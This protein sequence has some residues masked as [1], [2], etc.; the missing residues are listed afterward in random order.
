MISVRS[1][2]SHPDSDG[3]HVSPQRALRS[4]GNSN[5]QTSRVLKAANDAVEV[6]V[7]VKKFDLNAWSRG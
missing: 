3:R 2:A 1:I 5:Y 4:F 6:G 7:M